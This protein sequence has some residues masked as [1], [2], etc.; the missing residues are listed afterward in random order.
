MS[1]ARNVAL[2]TFYEDCSS[3]LDWSKNMAAMGQRLFSVYIYIEN[4]KNL[5]YRNH[6][7]D[8]NITEQEC[9]L[10][11]PLSRYSSSHHD[12][13]KKHGCQ[14]AGLIFPLYLYRKQ[15]PL[16]R[17]QYYLAEMF[18]WWLSTKFV[19]SVMIH[20]EN[21]AAR[22]RGLF[23]LYIYI[24]HFKNLFVKNHLTDFNLTWQKCSLGDP[25]SRF[26]LSRHDALKK[27]WPLGG[28]AIKFIQK[29]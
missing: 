12:A 4:F 19:Q 29:S 5:P 11:D 21:M 10:G 6:W 9:S 13:L 18:L 22:G 27:T 2:V 8:Y 7:T 3:R 1:L 26:S 17:F 14:E 15:K 25:L 28:R 16:D 23:S 24:K 20:E